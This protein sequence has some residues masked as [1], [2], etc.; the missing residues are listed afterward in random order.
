MPHMG[1]TWRTMMRTFTNMCTRMAPGIRMRT[2]TTTT[3]YMATRICTV[4]A[5]RRGSRPEL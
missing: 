5:R 3:M 1:T 4:T 2:L